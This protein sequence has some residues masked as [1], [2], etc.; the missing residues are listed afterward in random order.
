M[1]TFFLSPAAKGLYYIP[2]RSC[3]ALKQRNEQ[4]KRN[5]QQC[6]SSGLYYFREEEFLFERMFFS[7]E[8]QRNRNWLES[9]DEK[10]SPNAV[11]GFCLEREREERHTERERERESA[12][13]F[14][15]SPSSF[16]LLQPGTLLL[17]LKRERE[18]ERQSERDRERGLTHSLATVLSEEAAGACFFFFFF[19]FLTAAGNQGTDEVVHASYPGCFFPSMMHD[20]NDDGVQKRE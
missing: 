19:F 7:I 3:T 18:R 1:K 14:L 4:K 16:P 9:C 10:R 2:I 6:R 5:E 8:R 17:A 12:P 15:T 13:A 11:R 20:D